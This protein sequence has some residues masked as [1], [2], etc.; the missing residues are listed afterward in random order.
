MIL[1]HLFYHTYH[2]QKYQSYAE[3]QFRPCGIGSPGSFRRHGFLG[4]A[5]K[6][7]YLWLAAFLGIVDIAGGIIGCLYIGLQDGEAQ[8]CFHVASVTC[9][10][11]GGGICHIRMG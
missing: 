5:R 1:T 8:V 10:Y 9:G 3:S 2:M 11:I 4:G 6:Y 7:G